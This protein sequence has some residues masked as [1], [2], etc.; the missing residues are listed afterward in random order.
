MTKGPNTDQILH[1]H[2]LGIHEQA[3]TSQQH[4]CLAMQFFHLHLQVLLCVQNQVIE[5]IYRHTVD[6]N[7]VQ[8]LKWSIFQDIHHLDD[9]LV[10]TARNQVK[11]HLFL[12]RNCVELS[13]QNIN[14]QVKTCAGDVY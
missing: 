2:V 14:K 13:K 10:W 7:L 1:F 3:V 5:Q 11:S 4:L 8:N 9:T 6:Q 12:K